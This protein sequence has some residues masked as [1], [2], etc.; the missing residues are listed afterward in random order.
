MTELGYKKYV[1]ADLS[2]VLDFDLIPHLFCI[3]DANPGKSQNHREIIILH[4]AFYQ[5]IQEIFFLI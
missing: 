4:N 1:S 5:E 2:R 3:L